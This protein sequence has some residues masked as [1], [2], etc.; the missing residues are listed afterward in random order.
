M[1]SFISRNDHIFIAGH[2]GLAG[3]SICRS[4]V[5]KGYRNLIMIPK[6]KLDLSK[7]LDVKIWFA[8]NKPDVVILAAA[9]VGGII[10]NSNYPYDFLLENLLIQ[11]NV[12]K[13]SYE[14]EVKRLLF[15]S[16]S[17]A[18]PK[19]CKQP[20]KEE[21]L[22]TGSL[23]NTNESYALAKIAGMK[24]C[25]SLKFQK[26]FDAFSV[27]PSNLYG[28]GD[29]YESGNSH[30][31]ASLI[32]KFT[33]AKLQN[34]DEVIC[35]GD[36]SPKREFLHVDDLGDACVFCL[37]KFETKMQKNLIDQ[38]FSTNFI[39]IGTG[40]DISIHDLAN[41]IKKKVG[42]KGMIRW[43]VNKPNGTPRKKLDVSRIKN[44]GWE[45]KINI[46]DGI[47]NT[48]LDFKKKFT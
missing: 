28:P 21:Y 19:F 8:K 33:L 27:M 2:N 20:I 45:S 13:A 12:I 4:L 14:N 17:C 36:G 35:F 5:K 16:S 41:I 32:K 47:D 31:F 6:N 3:S 37:E 22:L 24:L 11:T 30:V 9:K 10:A 43:D 34:K 7:Q 23:E 39:N 1:K 44:L 38:K 29:N 40:S 48:I 18:Y 46:E 15:L 25:A 26:N 42:F